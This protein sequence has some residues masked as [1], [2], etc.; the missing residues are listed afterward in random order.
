[1]TQNISVVNGMLETHIADACRQVAVEE[2]SVFIKHEFDDAAI[3]KFAGAVG[4]GALDELRTSSE[5]V[6]MLKGAVRGMEIL[7]P[8]HAKACENHYD[9]S[10]NRAG[11]VEHRS[12]M[13]SMR[14]Y[15]M[16]SILDTVDNNGTRAY[17]KTYDRHLCS[18]RH[19][20]V[21]AGRV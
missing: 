6:V 17:Y 19:V 7:N 14:V 8:I 9:D 2:P 3:F 11:Y 12:H 15:R 21:A 1:M 18:V 20:G 16:K 10:C 4:V 13:L 5:S